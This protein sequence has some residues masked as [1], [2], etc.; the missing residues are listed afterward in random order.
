MD[1]KRVA[2][3]KVLT[4]EGL[5]VL[6]KVEAVTL[7]MERPVPEVYIREATVLHHAPASA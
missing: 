3:G 7:N 4:R 2:F 6:R 1:G 5:D